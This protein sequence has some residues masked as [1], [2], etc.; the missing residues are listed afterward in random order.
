[1]LSI[2]A[3]FAE[4][5]SKSVSSNIKWAVQEDRAVHR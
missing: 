1:M 4:E 3:G 5:E 2:L